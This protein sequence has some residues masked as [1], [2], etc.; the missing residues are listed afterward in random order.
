VLRPLG[1]AY[2]HDPGAWG[3]T[4]ELLVGPDLLAAPVTGPGTTPSVYLPA[5]RWIDL[6]TGR[7]LAGGGPAFT[8]PTPLD[9]LPLYARADA[10]VPFNLRTARGSW[11]GVDELTHPGRAGYLATSGA[12]LD[13]TGQPPQ[14][15]VFVPAAFR[16]GRVTIAGRPVA[17]RWNN[18][19]LP[20]V[21]IRLHGPDV[22]GTIALS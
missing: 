5:G 20:G 16:P 21:V 8:R 7:T 22:Q 18:G 14:V 17:W 11:W 12:R 6:Y 9:Q 1:Y 19:P 10:V 3:A 2:P 15:Q 13:L 4:Y